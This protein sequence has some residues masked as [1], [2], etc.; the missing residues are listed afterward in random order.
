M[1]KEQRL[2]SCSNLQRIKEITKLQ[3]MRDLYERQ[4]DLAVRRL[5]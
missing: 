2:V 3:R 5:K 1:T 4:H